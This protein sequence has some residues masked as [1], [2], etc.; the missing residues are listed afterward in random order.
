MVYV[1]AG[2]F[3]MGSN[4]YDVEKPIHE[5]T[6]DSFW[7]DRT[8]VTNAMFEKFAQ[9]SNY[10]T[11]A[12]KVGKSTIR[13]TGSKAW[14]QVNGADWQHP[15][16][17]QSSLAGLSEHP[18]VHISWNDANAY[19]SWQVVACRQRPIGKKPLAG[20]TV[21]HILGAKLPRMERF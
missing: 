20:L 16:G 10:R 11:D 4:R 18:I 12:E 19:C 13:D 1:P 6:L 7:I 8:E 9:A 14:A 3:I 2:P 17:P 15:Q 5:V 21:A